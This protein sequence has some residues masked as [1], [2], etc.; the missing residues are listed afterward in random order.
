MVSNEESAVG[1]LGTAVEK[2]GLGS[3][4]FGGM[5]DISNNSENTEVLLR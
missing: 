4:S 1:D 5:M 3:K 2:D